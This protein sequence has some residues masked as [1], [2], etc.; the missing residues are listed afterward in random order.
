[1][2]TIKTKHMNAKSIIKP[3]LTLFLCILSLL[4]AAQTDPDDPGGDPDA[5]IDGGATVLVAA[6]AAYGIKMIRE[7]KRSRSDQPEQ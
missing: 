5:P 7:R 2:L 4:A 3:V 1:M 6:A